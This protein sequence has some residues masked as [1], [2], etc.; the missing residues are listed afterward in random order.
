MAAYK[1]KLVA[2]GGNIEID[3]DATGK[4]TF[5]VYEV[6]LARAGVERLLYLAGTIESVLEQYGLTSLEVEKA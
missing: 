1:M 3:T 4:V 2:P 5:P 6:N